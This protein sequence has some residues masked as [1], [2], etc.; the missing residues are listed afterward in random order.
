VC[1]RLRVEGELA[2]RVMPATSQDTSENGEV[3]DAAHEEVPGGGDGSAYQ[4]F[5]IGDPPCTIAD[6]LTYIALDRLHIYS[7]ALPAE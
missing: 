5:L 3:V 4:H 2:I 1:Y 6:T 7:A